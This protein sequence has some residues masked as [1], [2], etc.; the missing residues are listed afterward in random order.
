MNSNLV[1]LLYVSNSL[2]PASTERSEVE[3]ILSVARERNAASSITGALV[4]TG[5]HFAQLLEGSREAVDELMA[6]ILADERHER[7][8]V[9]EVR[10]VAER[11]FPGWSTAYAGPSFYVEGH[12]RAL[13]DAE[14]PG[15]RTQAARAL[16]RLMKEFAA[17][18][19]VDRL[20]V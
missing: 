18:G 12:V 9:V 8:D 10:E 5:R 3:R 6:C 13:F 17:A 1:S 7:V 14:A 19:G 2:L 16:T 20:S 4:F 11:S 15:D